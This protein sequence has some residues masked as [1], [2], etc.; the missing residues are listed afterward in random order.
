MDRELLWLWLAEI[1]GID[2]HRINQLIHCFGD[3]SDL[4]KAK[5]EVINRETRSLNFPEQITQSLLL[6]DMRKLQQDY[7][8]MLKKNIYF[9]TK[10][11]KGFPERLRRM[12]ESPNFLFYSGTLPKDEVPSLAV[13]G[14][15][16]CSTYG[17]E[18]ATCFSRIFA[19]LGIQI[20]SGMARGIDGYAHVGALEADGYTCAVLGFGVDLCYPSEHRVLKKKILDHGAVIS[21]YPPGTPGFRH[22]FPARN[23]LISG[24]ADGVLVV[25]AAKKSGTLITVDFALNQGKNLYAIPGR[26]GDVLSGG[27]NELFKIGAKPVTEPDDILSDFSIQVVKEQK[28]EKNEKNKL[29]LE[30]EEKIVYACLDLFPKHLEEIMSLTGFSID[31]I[32]RLLFSLELKEYI[33]QPE[34]NY[35]IIS[36]RNQASLDLQSGI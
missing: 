30:T 27:C 36:Y 33:R 31:R 23:R 12:P 17:K 19:G 25:E 22:N 15:R 11:A 1:P 24:L 35:Y 9:V 18:I 8:A 34:K 2:Y 16:N 5:D 10:E 20:I 21:E 28:N 7:E 29:T 4:Y 13:I 32:T 26:I 3:I 14:A 6:R